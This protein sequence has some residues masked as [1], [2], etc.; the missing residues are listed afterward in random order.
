[1]EGRCVVIACVHLFVSWQ[2][3][4]NR[5]WGRAS[6]RSSKCS[7]EH[8]RPVGGGAVPPVGSLL[9]GVQHGVDKT[10]HQ[11]GV[12][13]NVDFAKKTRFEQSEVVGPG[14][15]LLH[16]TLGD[17]TPEG[18]G[19]GTA[20]GQSWRRIV[21]HLRPDREMVTCYLFTNRGVQMRFPSASAI[22]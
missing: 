4:G 15:L 21:N 1:M 11:W 9:R 7:N 12:A 22:L 20:I 18:L 10:R 19:V 3:K 5:G 13:A 6:Q 14:G 16:Q 2:T 17:N 8:G